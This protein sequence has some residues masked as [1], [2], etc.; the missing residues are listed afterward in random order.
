MSF[1]SSVIND[2]RS[3]IPGE[4]AFDAPYTG[5][6]ATLDSTS[7][8]DNVFGRAFTYKSNT[9]ETVQAGGSGVF[10][11]IMVNPKAFAQQNVSTSLTG[12]DKI[13]NGSPSEFLVEGEVY[14]LLS[15]GTAVTIGDP[16]YFV[17]ADG[18]LGAGTAAAGQTKIAGATVVR[19]NPS[20]A[21]APALAVVRIKP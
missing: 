11:G 15:A 4:I 3:G 17:N 16:V 10:A 14:V 13:A 5:I 19:H 9:A 7:A 8:A 1:P 12:G 21:N 6:T 2:L 20:A 18:T